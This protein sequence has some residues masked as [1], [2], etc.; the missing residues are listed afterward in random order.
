M[1]LIG[2]TKIKNMRNISQTAYVHARA[3]SPVSYHDDDVGTVVTFNTNYP[4]YV[5][6]PTVH[7]LHEYVAHPHDHRGPNST[8]L[9]ELKWTLARHATDVCTSICFEDLAYGIMP[10]RDVATRA[11]IRIQSIF[12]MVLARRRIRSRVMNKRKWEAIPVLARFFKK[13]L[14]KNVKIAQLQAVRKIQAFFRGTFTRYQFCRRIH[15]VIVIGYAWRQYKMRLLCQ[16]SLRRLD[17]PLIISIDEIIN[18][19]VQH[20]HS[21]KL[22]VRI[23]L[24]SFSLLHIVTGSDIAASIVARKPNLTWTLEPVRIKA[25]VN[26]ELVSSDSFVG[27][28]GA[29]HERACHGHANGAAEVSSDQDESESSSS[30]SGDD[31]D[32]PKSAPRLLSKKVSEAVGGS[33]SRSFNTLSRSVRSLV[34]DKMDRSVTETDKEKSNS[35]SCKNKPSSI[36]P[37]GSFREMVGG[38][39][40]FNYQVILPGC[41]GNSVLRFDVMDEG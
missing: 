19:P 24:Y 27:A 33:F 6:G 11:I 20:V 25:R 29:S 40:V 17:R 39:C 8:N 4:M 22:T 14:K 2:D 31:E 10:C 21:G 9:H 5:P 15:A 23:S 3:H 32:V 37:N 30:S 41:H 1:S 18:F 36:S 7:L 16:R 35:H 38:D 13:G 26:G 34:A 12:R 28:A